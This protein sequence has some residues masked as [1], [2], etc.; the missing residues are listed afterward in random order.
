M[1]ARIRWFVGMLVVT[2]GPLAWAALPEPPKEMAPWAMPWGNDVP[3]L[4]SADGL[5]DKPAAKNGPVVA[6]DGHFYSGDQRVRF[7]GFSI[8]FSGAFPTHEQADEVARRLAHFGVNAIRFHHI[9]NQPYP[10]GIFADRT[11]ETLS[12][13]A[14]DRLDYFIAALKSQGIYSDLN[15]HV[16]RWWSK[17]HH[18]ANADKLPEYD[19]MVD[20]FDPRLIAAQKQYAR[21]LLTHVNPYTHTRYADEPAVCFL[22][23]N[24]ENT[25]FLWGGEQKLADLPEPYGA[26]LTKLWNEWLTKK[27]AGRDA[28]QSAWSKGS[29][30]LGPNLL[31]KLVSETNG[32]TKEQHESAKMSLQPL[33]GD[34]PGLTFNIDSIDS[35]SWHLQYGCAGLKLR[36][37]QFYTVLLAARAESPREISVSVGQAHA[38]WGNLGLATN[39]QLTP[40]QKTFRLGF[41]CGADDDNAR[42]SLI[43]GQSKARVS[44]SR[45]ELHEGGREGLGQDEDPAHGTV[46]RGYPDH[47]YTEARRADW[48]D[49]LQQTDQAYFTGM[50]RFLKQDL[51][52]K[53]PITGTIGLGPLGTLSQSH[54]DFVDAHAYWDHPRF[55]RRPWDGSDWVEKNQPMVDDPAGATLWQL[56][57]TRVAGKPFTVT[58]YNH[59]APNEWQAECVPMIAA[60]AALQDWDGVFLF[61]YVASNRYREMDHMRNYFD[62]EG[63]PQKMDLMPFGARLF[64]GGQLQP[65]SGRKLVSAS[66][67]QMLET[68]SKYYYTL[69]PFVRDVL[70]VTLQDALACRLQMAFEPTS[71]TGPCV[72]DPRVSWTSSGAD[73]GT[74]RFIVRDPNAAVFVGF[75]SGGP[76]PI[77]LGSVRIERL[78]TP[79]ATILITPAMSGESIDRAR[80][81]LVAAVAR[82]GNAGMKWDAARHTVSNHWGKPTPLIEVVHG[83]L[84]IATSGPTTAFALKP[85]GTR[86]EPIP[87]K[88][89]QGRTTID[90][91]TQHT[92][93]YE[94]DH[95]NP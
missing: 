62:F 19:K 20:L 35:T 59:A 4:V 69:W 76:M 63:N 79:F 31:P 53:C 24:N 41:V 70:H 44:L 1:G 65:L 85:D 82:G 39:L 48:Y 51:G 42:V 26:E 6:R 58:E 45:I 11:L 23:I 54:M 49:F 66:R 46:A 2:L 68:G 18:W 36:K 47:G 28:L 75:A 74:G 22:E 8:A 16:S 43:L 89:D 78:D 34:E 17:A 30:P 50:T 95:T 27:Y 33:Q 7:W 37:G 55:P 71:E 88:T 90:L 64:L 32:W 92:L 87:V 73:S 72:P 80:R 10:N 52:V 15:L 94:L 21:D 91:G 14:L 60:Y 38:P 25:L 5:I 61:D 81:L 93:W 56:A 84:S 12:P 13:E 67:L 77:D 83:K 3:G 29:E 9:D 86:G 40:E 57:A